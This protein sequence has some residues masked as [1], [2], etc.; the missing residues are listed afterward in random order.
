MPVQV[1][2][3]H[4]PDQTPYNLPKKLQKFLGYYK[5]AR[6]YRWALNQTFF[7]YNYNTVII[8]EGC[9]HCYTSISCHVLFSASFLHAVTRNNALS[10]DLDV[11]PDFFEYFT[12]VRP[13]LRQDT[14]LFCVSAWN[15][16]GKKHLIG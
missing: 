6:H 13:L 8:T 2:L 4:Q 15:D 16:N 12:A 9:I 10:D 11:A 14:S 7:R 1:T 5:I 3:I